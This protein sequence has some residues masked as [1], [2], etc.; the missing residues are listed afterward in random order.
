MAKETLR[1]YFE[2]FAKEVGSPNYEFADGAIKRITKWVTMGL[3]DPTQK[4][5]TPQQDAWKELNRNLQDNAK[6]Y[7]KR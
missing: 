6:Q 5:K 1:E 7:G 2:D 4:V 3:V